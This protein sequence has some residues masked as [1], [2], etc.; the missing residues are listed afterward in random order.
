[1]IW[2]SRP[3]MVVYQMYFIVGGA[4]IAVIILIVVVVIRK[5]REGTSLSKITKGLLASSDND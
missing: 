3:F 4:L 1:M 2:A 5:R